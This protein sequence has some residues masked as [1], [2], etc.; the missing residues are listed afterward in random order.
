MMNKQFLYTSAITAILIAI[1]LTIVQ[2]VPEKPLLL[3][4]RL[5][6]SAGW[7]QV[8]IAIIYGAL[9]SYKMQD[10]KERP[11]W[12]SPGLVAFFYC[13]LRAVTFRRNCRFCLSDDRKVAFTRSGNHT[14]R[15]DL[16]V[17]G[18]VYAD[19]FPEYVA[20]FGTCLVQPALLFRGI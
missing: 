16:P 11:K 6:P 18:I 20:A 12:Q 10:R 15:P 13:F 8:G 3:S 19:T 4:E 7:I 5:M 14:G 2:V 9:L 17:G 1:L